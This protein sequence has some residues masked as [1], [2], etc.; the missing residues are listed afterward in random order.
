[1]STTP[2]SKRKIVTGAMRP[3]GPAAMTPERLA[4][5]RALKAFGIP[6]ERL[7]EGRCIGAHKWPGVGIVTGTVGDVTERRFSS[8]KLDRLGRLL[9][10][11][12]TAL[13]DT[14]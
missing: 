13:Q 4:A 3:I 2:K 1:M 11:A 6:I 14:P 8:A 9:L 12:T 7:R 10:E 5:L